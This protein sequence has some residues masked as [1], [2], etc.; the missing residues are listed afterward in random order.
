[1]HDTKTTLEQLKQKMAAFV[2]E[3]EWKQFHS[4]KNLSM[5]IAVEAA[6]L[7]EKFMWGDVQESRIKCETSRLEVEHEVADILI[8]IL[9]FA[10]STNIDLARAV[11]LK[12]AEIAAKYP[13][14][15]CRGKAE[16]YDQL[17]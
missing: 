17:Q 7:M 8:G 2:A 14:N 15:K 6:E 11:E 9:A 13:V 4:P 12:L 1:M 16:K 3:R 10:N 5:S